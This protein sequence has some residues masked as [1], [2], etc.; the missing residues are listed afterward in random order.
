[1]ETLCEVLMRRDGLSGQQAEDEI[2]YARQLVEDGADPEEV[3]YAEF[4]LEP[5]YVFEL[6]GG[7]I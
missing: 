5:D 1:M 2:E 7:L 4:G 6:V 3:L